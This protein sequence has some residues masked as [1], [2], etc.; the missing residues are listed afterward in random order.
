MAMEARVAE[1]DGWQH[2]SMLPYVRQQVKLDKVKYLVPGTSR[3]V[4]VADAGI[5]PKLTSAITE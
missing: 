2:S 1:A 3:Q 4:T 5:C